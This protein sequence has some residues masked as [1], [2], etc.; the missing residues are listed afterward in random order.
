MNPRDSARALLAL[1]AGQPVQAVPPERVA[2]LLRNAR[3]GDDDARRALL[4][5][6]QQLRTLPALVAAAVAEDGA[7]VIVADGSQMPRA[8]AERHLAIRE[9]RGVYPSLRQPLLRA[10]RHALDPAALRFMADQARAEWSLPVAASPEPKSPPEPQTPPAEPQTRPPEPPTQPSPKPPSQPSPAGGRSPNLS[11]K[12]NPAGPRAALRGFL[13][14]SAELV[15]PALEMLASVSHGAVDDAHQL[16]RALDLPDP[17]RFNDS[18]IIELVRATRESLPRNVR[19][20]QRRPA[21]RIMAGQVVDDGDT[22]RLLVAPSLTA[23]R[24]LAMSRGVGQAYA[25]LI[26]VDVGAALGLMLSTPAVR[27]LV[28]LKGDPAEQLWRHALCAGLL[29]AR[30]AAAVAVAVA[31]AMG[32]NADPEASPRDVWAMVRDQARG[33]ARAA[34]GFD[35]GAERTDDLLLPPWPDGLTDDNAAD[36]AL[37][38]ALGAAVAASDALS[39]RERADDGL[40]LR[41]Q[42]L[43]AVIESHGESG[44]GHGEGAV[45][46]EARGLAA[47]AG[48][49]T[50]LGEV[51]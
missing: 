21:P 17:A 32:A 49:K 51:A 42:G 1:L 5:L 12:P 8:E 34:V 16:V 4:S 14:A 13:K 19:P 46:D 11:P 15:A 40:L 31:D 41:R 48:W 30:L 27:R 23:G 36:A 29:E 9:E 6:V 24:S 25:R 50:M 28:G 38:L 10:R 45:V 20:L 18:V 3:D 7:I 43:Q 26:G 44:E 2:A 37:R 47:A 22:V 39:I 33:A 35:A